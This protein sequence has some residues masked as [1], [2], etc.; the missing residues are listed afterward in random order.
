MRDYATLESRLAAA[1]DRIRVGVDRL[2]DDAASGEA[3]DNLAALNTQLEDERMVNAQLQER[4]RVLSERQDTATAPLQSQVD[5]QSRQMAELDGELQRL[6]AVNADLRDLSAQLRSAA[7]A[8]VAEPELIN[9][10]L[11]AEVDALQAQRSAD[12]AE[13]DAILADL[14]PIVEE[15]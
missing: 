11:M 10:A 3:A 14:K 2:G 7:S 4:L 5:A 13:L 12:R 6:R 8:G 9:K 15:A 1:L